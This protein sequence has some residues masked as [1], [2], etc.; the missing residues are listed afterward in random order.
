MAL[1]TP[2]RVLAEPRAETAPSDTQS[3]VERGAGTRRV[4]VN[5]SEVVYR[6]LDEL[7]KRKGTTMAEVLRDAIALEKWVEDERAQGGRILVERNGEV[8]ELVLR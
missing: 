6:M 8:R 4:N 1:T 2:E 7:A 3:R 5:F